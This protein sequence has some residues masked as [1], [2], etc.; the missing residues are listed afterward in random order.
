MN[1]GPLEHLCDRMDGAVAASVIGADGTVVSTV[2]GETTVDGVEL[3]ALWAEY[4]G[5]LRQV[6]QNAQM[7]AAGA[8]EELLLSSERVVTII[9]PLGPEL[10]LAFAVLRDASCGKARYLCRV[11]APRLIELIG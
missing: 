5:L 11:T 4:S 1:R 10:F 8:L 7:L 9:R 2:R 6:R 3:E